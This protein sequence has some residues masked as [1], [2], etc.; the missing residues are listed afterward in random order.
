[1][2]YEQKFRLREELKQKRQDVSESSEDYIEFI[3]ER[4]QLLGISDETKLFIFVN[5]LCSSEM[6][7]EIL[8]NW[9]KSFEKAVS[10]AQHKVWVYEMIE[11]PNYFSKAT[12]ECPREETKL[13]FQSNETPAPK[14]VET[15]HSESVKDLKKKLKT[16]KEEL[17]SMRNFKVDDNVRDKFS[18]EL[19]PILTE[20]G[21]CKGNLAKVHI[22][23]RRPVEVFFADTFTG[24]PF[25]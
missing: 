13:S 25:A 15:F 2:S 9:P 20:L 5:G 23:E 24:K 19:C 16:L 22:T 11:S 8:M 7:H 1:M 17:N 12:F 3:E 21:F 14:L 6:K 18:Y 4:C 10:I